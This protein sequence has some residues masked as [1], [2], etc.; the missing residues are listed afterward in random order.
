MNYQELRDF[1]ACL[2]YF[3]DCKSEILEKFFNSFN[4]ELSGI[5]Q[6]NSA[7]GVNLE[8]KDINCKIIEVEPSKALSYYIELSRK[9]ELTLREES[10][11]SFARKMGYAV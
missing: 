4:E 1:N 5:D 11:L 9:C 10:I 7:L 3:C 2:N 8:T 6:I